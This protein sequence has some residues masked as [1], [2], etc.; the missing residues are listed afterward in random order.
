AKV[1]LEDKDDDEVTKIEVFTEDYENED[2]DELDGI[3][4]EKVTFDDSGD[5]KK[6]SITIKGK[7]YTIDE[8]E[9]DDM[10]VE[11]T[12][13]DSDIEDFENL[14]NAYDDGKKL[15]VDVVLD[16]GDIIEIT[17]Y[18][19]Y[20]TGRLVDFE[21]DELT[22]EG[23]DSETKASYTFEDPDDISMKDFTGKSFETLED[24]ID[25]LKDQDEDDKLD[26]YDEQKF[27][28]KFEVDE[29]GMIDSDITGKY[30]KD[31]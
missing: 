25:W 6:G 11:I 13:G 28:L 19:C 26:L 2:K 24:L 10:E 14:Y 30:E 22:I 31:K 23:K 15:K 7:K 21:D 4:I 8:D 3:E 27:T 20:V 9:M 29:D 16:D 1:S 17:G 5:E 18:V 12:D